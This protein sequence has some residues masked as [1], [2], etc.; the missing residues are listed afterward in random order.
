MNDKEKPYIPV[1][2]KEKIELEK[3]KNNN[4]IDF[5]IFIKSL[6]EKRNTMLD[7]E[8][9][10]AIQSILSKYGIQID[11]QSIIEIAQTILI[12]KDH[13]IDTPRKVHEFIYKANL[14]ADK[15]T[16]KKPTYVAN[17]YSDGELVYDTWVCPNCDEDYEVDYHDYD[18]C[19][20]CGQ[21]IDWSE[22][23]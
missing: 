19:P 8:I 12:L 22:E 3:L 14:L 10:N 16:P 18:Y 6:C 20:K 1:Y 11:Q 15:D 7:F 13:G 5:N 2:R 23:E 9:S 21:A 4:L 17:G